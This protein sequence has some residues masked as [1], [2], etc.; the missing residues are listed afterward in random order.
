M[1][2][3]YW[4][5]QRLRNDKFGGILSD[6][7]DWNSD[8]SQTIQIISNSMIASKKSKKIR[9]SS[10][11]TATISERM[12]P[13]IDSFG[14]RGHLIKSCRFSR[15]WFNNITYISEKRLLNLFLAGSG[16]CYLFDALCNFED[17]LLGYVT[18]N[19]CVNVNEVEAYR[20]DFDSLLF[21]DCVFTFI[22]I[23]T[24]QVRVN[25]IAKFTGPLFLPVRRL[26][27]DDRAGA[28]RCG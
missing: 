6:W 12:W 25:L 5:H 22:I 26:L 18:P 7:S 27:G 10:H 1:S 4:G 14:S 2:S 8:F 19:I 9:S 13:K 21:G 20:A 3:P 23:V 16:T 15:R 17:R 11:V 28:N 24:C